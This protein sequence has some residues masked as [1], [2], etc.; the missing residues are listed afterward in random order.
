MKDININIEKYMFTP[1]PCDSIN[2]VLY[3]NLMETLVKNKQILEN[4]ITSIYKFELL[5][6]DYLM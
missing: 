4:M 1:F 6:L 2:Y 5:L 3:L